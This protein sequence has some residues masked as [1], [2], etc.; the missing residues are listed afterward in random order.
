VSDKLDKLVADARREFGVREAKEVDWDKVDAGLFERIER[1]ERGARSQ[2]APSARRG[3]TLV[4]VGF[5]AAAALAAVVVGKGRDAIDPAGMAAPEGAATIAAIDANGADALLVDG[6]PAARGASLRLGDVLE[7]RSAR[8]TLDRPGKL[9]AMLEPGSRTVVTHVRGALVL[10]LDQG[11]VEA[12]VVPVATGEAFAVDV[13]GARVAVHGTHLRVAREGE[14]V[15][16]DLSEGVVAVGRAPREGSVIG[17]VINAPAH[18]EFLARDPVGT[19]TQTHE[20]SAVR[21]PLETR[22]A[23]ADRPYAPPHVDATARPS[24]AAEPRVEPRAAIAGGAGAALPAPEATST[25]AASVTAS[26]KPAASASPEES[27]ALAV[28]AC[29]STRPHADNVTVVVSTTLHLE[30]ADDGSVRAARFEPPVAPDVNTCAAQAIYRAR[31]THGGA[32]T[33]AVDFTN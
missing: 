17:T 28:R 21:R 19:L 18:V 6:Q 5:A 14:R 25:A 20:L 27:L 2:F 23:A 12:Q 24:P 30:L 15:V 29:M 32:A 10:E 1:E 16:V 11:A 13:D 26:A 4:A 22:G 31:F 3:V 33:I 9:T 8:A 7:T